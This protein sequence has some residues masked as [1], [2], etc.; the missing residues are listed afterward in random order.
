MVHC[1]LSAPLYHAGR[2]APL[3]DRLLRGTE[4]GRCADGR[5]ARRSPA[6][7]TEDAAP[8]VLVPA[9]DAVELTAAEIESGEHDAIASGALG[10]GT[11]KWRLRVES[12]RLAAVQS[13]LSSPSG[14]LT[15]VSH[16]DDARGLG[17]CPQRCCP[18]LPR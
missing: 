2:L 7:T 4:S 12:G 17:I 5:G 14:H 6:A 15:N 1:R 16:A 10:D 18:R 11:R 8:A 9:T 13:L 3:M